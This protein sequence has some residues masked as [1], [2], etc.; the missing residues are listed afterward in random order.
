MQQFFLKDPIAVI[1][2][3]CRFPGGV[4]DMRGFWELLEN[5]V[6]AVTRMPPDRFSLESF[7]SKSPELPGHSYTDAA[8]VL[9]SIKDFDPGFFGLSGKEAANMDPQQRLM[10]ELTWEALEAAGIPPSTLR[11]SDTGVFIGA[12]NMDFTVRGSMDPEGLSPHAVTGSALSIIANRISYIFDFHGPSLVVDTACSSSLAA[13][14]DACRAVGEGGTDLAVAGGIN[15]LMSPL[16]F[17]GFAKA[18]MLSPDGRCKMFDASGN[19]FVRAEGGGVVVLKKLSRALRDGDGVMALIAGAGMNSDGRT[20]GLALPGLRAQTELLRDI[21]GHPGIDTSKIA[22]IEAHGTGTPAGDPVEARAVGEVLGKHLKGRRPLYVGSVKTNIGHLE[23]ASGAAGL[24]KAVLVLQR[25]RIPPNLHFTV[26]NPN[27][28][29]DTLNLR[30][31]TRAI[32]LPLRGDGALVGLNSFGFGGTNVHILLRKAP[33]RSRRRSFPVPDGD[34]PPLFLSARSEKSLRAFAV[35]L[36]DGLE[37]TDGRQLP[38][39]ARTLALCRD[40]QRLRAVFD[41]GGI[42]DLTQRLRGFGHAAGGSGRLN[43]V[44][45]AV[46]ENCPGAFVFSGNG[47]QWP[48]MGGALFRENAVF[49]QAMEEIDAFFRTLRN[50][51]IIDVMLNPEKYPHAVSHTEESQPLLFAVQIGLVRA[52][53]A[54]GIR[55]DFVFG[56]SVGEIAAACAADALTI[57]DACTIVHFRSLL[58]S[59]LRNTGLMAVAPAGENSLEDLLAPFNGEVEITAVNSEK[60]VT[61]GGETDAVR[62]CVQKL[63]KSGIAA[64]L[65]DLPYPFH[66]RRIDALKDDF[67][68]AIK[69]IRPR[70]A[71]IPFL[72]TAGAGE[73]RRPGKVYWWRNMRN[74]VCFGDAVSS[75]LMLGS[76]IFLEIGPHPVLLGYIQEGIGKSGLSA[77]AQPVMQRNGHNGRHFETAWREAWKKG[78]T[79]R[80]ED[81]KRGSFVGASLPAYAWDKEY[82]WV[83]DTPECREFITA[84]TVHPL[85]GRRMP[86]AARGFENLLTVADF[87]WLADHRIGGAL[88]FPAA[89]IVEI[90]ATAAELL[91]PD[92]KRAPEHL[93][94]YR[95]LRL[96]P[97]HAV[98]VRITEDEEDGALRF[99]SRPYM[100]DERWS[101]CAAARVRSALPPEDG[102]RV[103]D[104]AGFG[105]ATDAGTVYAEAAGNGF[106]YGPLFRTLETVWTKEGKDGPAVLA[107]LL[108]AAP[109]TAA[110][111]RTPPVLLDGGLHALLPLLQAAEHTRGA[112]F[113]PS[114]VACITRYAAG[115]PRFV[116]AR[117]R[118]VGKRQATADVDYLDADGK[119]MLSLEQCRF[120]KVDRPADASPSAFVVRALP[121]PGP[122]GPAGRSDVFACDMRAVRLAAR[123]AFSA[124]R[125]GGAGRSESHERRILRQTALKQVHEAVQGLREGKD[126]GRFFTWDE[127]CVSG[128]VDVEQ[129]AWLRRIM[130]HLVGAGLARESGEGWELLHPEN[131]PPADVL[132]RT[133]VARAPG[134]LPENILLARV[135]GRAGDF[136]RSGSAARS[137]PDS[138]FSAYFSLS[139]ALRP[140]IN[141]LN[142]C[143]RTLSAGTGA[144]RLLRIL[145]LSAAPAAFAGELVPYAAGKN[146]RIDCAGRD[147]A[148]SDGL[149]QIFASVPEASAVPVDLAAQQPELAGS[150]HIIVAPFR[151][152]AETHALRALERCREMLVPGGVLCLLEH[153]P[154]IFTDLTFGADPRWWRRSSGEQ[155]CASGLHSPEAWIS[156]LREAGFTDI[157]RVDD[158]DGDE[159]PAFLL[160]ARKSRDDAAPKKDASGLSPECTATGSEGS[161]PQGGSTE[162]GQTS[163]RLLPEFVI[164]ARE[165]GTPSG[166]LG[167]ALREE[168]RGLGVQ[169]DLLHG[170][171]SALSSGVLFDPLAPGPWRELLDAAPPD[172]PLELI[173]L[174]G[175]DIAVHPDEREFAFSL[176]YGPAAAAAFAAAWDASRRPAEMILVTGGAVAA[177]MPIPELHPERSGE[178]GRAYPA[179][180][181][182]PVLPS[183]GAVWGFGRVLVNEMP[184]L[185][186]KLLDWYGSEAEL[187]RLARELVDAAGN[188][189]DREVLLSGRGRF[190]LRLVP[191][192]E[193]EELSGPCGARLV[194]DAPGSLKNLYWRKSPSQNPGPGRTRIAVKAVGLNFRDVMWSK[195]LL[196]EEALE[197]GFAG[198]GLGMECSGVIE[199]VGEGV[200]GFKPGDE[201]F[202]FVPDAF[203]SL[204]ITDAGA[205]TVKPGGMTF[206]QAAT[207][208]VVFMTAWYGLAHLAGMQAGESVLIHG[209]AGGVGLAAVQVAAHLGVEVFATAGSEEKQAFL[210]GLGLKNIF[211]SR[212]TD[213]ARQIKKVTSGR[214]VDVVLNSLSGEFIA[215][216]LS[217]LKPFGRFLELG[218]KDFYADS[219]MRMH[220]FSNN[221]SF[222]GIDVDGLFAGRRELAVKLFTGLTA[223]FDEGKLRPLPHVCY[224]RVRAVDAFRVMQHSAHIGK[225]V[226]L[227]DDAETAVRPLPLRQSRLSLRGDAA[228]LVTGGTGGFGLAAARR[229]ARRGA[230]RLILVSRSGVKDAEAGAVMD[231]MRNSG[232]DVVVLKADVSSRRSLARALR[233][234]TEGDVPLAGVVHAA[235]VLDDGLI[236]GLT[237]ERIRKV[238]AAKAVGAWNLHELTKDARLDFFVL[239]SSA[240]TTFGNPGQASYVAANAALESLAAYRRQTGLPATVIGWGPI[241]GDGMLQRNPKV[242]AMLK[243]LLGA[244]ALA[245]DEALDRLEQCI[246][247]NIADSHYFC[248]SRQGRPGISML[249]S[250]IFERLIPAKRAGED[251]GMPPPERIR[252]APP[253]EGRALLMEL[254]RAEIADILGI[255]AERLAADTPLADE[256]MDSLMAAELGVSIDQTFDLDGYSVPLTDKMNT[257]DL[258]ASLY[259]VIMD[260]GAKSGA[261]SDELHFVDALSRQH[262]LELPDSVKREISL[263]IGGS[264]RD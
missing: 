178:D 43:A 199:E 98:S 10:L 172:R 261:A 46:G 252:R 68:A 236:V 64:K 158:P 22:Y 215:A 114:A 6:D 253:E 125:D 104:P 191:A 244:E 184:A 165:P 121:A 4:H 194:F 204:A 264:K 1:G 66:T 74:R 232:V 110:G 34:D 80:R 39:I 237:P 185:R 212:S 213:F 228:Y 16:P 47:G 13:L 246:I 168:L 234:A 175:Y 41:C 255:G 11:G 127:L 183:Q 40:H 182:R 214:G 60:S 152:H 107:S 170:G 82:L 87:P 241:N 113:L 35:S 150:R 29:F 36:A 153:R 177:G 163:R 67:L 157:A 21:Y 263:S 93:V 58:Q 146:I 122:A 161:S 140:Y 219:P 103:T 128:T 143:V 260:R 242:A 18:R 187:D 189:G 257:A 91:H 44:G 89:C 131:V 106:G 7:F 238:M 105:V 126:G 145:L 9:T 19:G 112:V 123:A 96:S 167:I 210:R 211:S 75:A 81:L 32:D 160:L 195:G 208:P 28:D 262:A 86:R 56:H 162:C 155:G 24:L 133:A 171:C 54:K 83:A 188:T 258:A 141:G 26:P 229:L 49:A 139:P 144:G 124:G 48:G 130:R 156:A 3:S 78:W 190:T 201:V 14:Y 31:P 179:V 61:L 42:Q 197:N 186:T 193:G 33:Q 205:V 221:L 203:G 102:I 251:G 200:S 233:E 159:G 240:T 85:L 77:L 119:I 148:E 207:L 132:W 174:L 142:A 2:A 70:T 63:K 137:L 245:P 27:I 94:I 51:S 239:Y 100:S 15:I 218:K 71:T 90:F 116:H 20:T 176:E 97:E 249:S 111:M 88:L 256:G 53:R 52:L 225:L 12:S 108:P 50:V 115:S 147:K 8:G 45:E 99:E 259:P 149:E 243:N 230:G 72:S 154:D 17:I 59:R 247:H 220:P 76:R 117:L 223:L 30:V 118:T 109:E 55:P 209:A 231:A 173:N 135:T 57:Q 134:Y 95:P 235:A 224:P 254:L 69:D 120:R 129:E 226:V 92:E 196:P 37:N 73:M 84:P 192:V 138:L 164:A 101:L 79:L 180:G 151:L 250:A 23:P 198:A 217:A 62:A 248:L 169:A 227:L 65:L 206:S 216:G 136:L 181:G 166:R 222:F 25:G 202:G 38:D 5:G